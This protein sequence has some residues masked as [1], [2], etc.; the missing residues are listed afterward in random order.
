MTEIC[1]TNTHNQNQSSLFR[2]RQKDKQTIIICQYQKERQKFRKVGN[3]YLKT[4][5]QKDIMKGRQIFW[6]YQK[7]K[8]ITTDRLKDR[9]EGKSQTEEFRTKD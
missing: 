3:K 4:E 2:K 6:Q 5:G 1:D 9:A 7:Q 8:K